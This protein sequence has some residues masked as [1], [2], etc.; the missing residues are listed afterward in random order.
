LIPAQFAKHL[1]SFQNYI[2]KT[3]LL[4]EDNLRNTLK[5]TLT[6]ST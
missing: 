1:L 6:N 2:M 4:N 3:H 5:T